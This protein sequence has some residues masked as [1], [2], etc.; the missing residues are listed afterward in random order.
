MPSLNQMGSNNHTQTATYAG[1]SKYDFE[2]KW[3]RSL[4]DCFQFGGQESCKWNMVEF[5]RW[6]VYTESYSDLQVG[7]ASKVMCRII[8]YKYSNYLE[9]VINV[10]F[11]PYS[12]F[13][14]SQGRLQIITMKYAGTTR[15]RR[16][17]Q[18]FLE[19]NCKRL[20]NRCVWFSFK[21]ATDFTLSKHIDLQLSYG[22][23]MAWRW[24]PIFRKWGAAHPYFN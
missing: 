24:I 5:R 7:K 20:Q 1:G 15:L 8:S 2:R 6:L 18:W 21:E 23:E 16:K 13:W 12:L 22:A 11:L 4:K 3:M 17:P 19:L 10:E 14:E 9:V